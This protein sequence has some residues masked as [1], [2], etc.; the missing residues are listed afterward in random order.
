MTNFGKTWTND[1]PG[2]KDQLKMNLR[3][4]KNLKAR[5][6]R[7]INAI[8]NQSR[9]LDN[10]SETFKQKDAKYY[11]MI[12]SSLKDHDKDRAAGYA[13]ELA[14]IRK[15]HRNVTQVKLA[16]EQISL[17]IST[18]KDIGDIATSLA[19]AMSVIKSASNMMSNVYPQANQEF[20]TLSDLLG[21]V[22]A[23]AGYSSGMNIDFSVANEEAGKILADAE[24]QIEKDVQHTLPEVPDN[25]QGLQL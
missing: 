7:G 15:N 23:D 18:A 1:Q 25:H 8:N 20:D 17:R 24:K 9:K 6:S 4:E 16:L 2:I 14:E 12:V 11:K 21:G 3:P 13:N 5:M 22:I 19:P 10:L